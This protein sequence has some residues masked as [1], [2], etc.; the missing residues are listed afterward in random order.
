MK[1]LYMIITV[2]LFLALA[3][4]FEGMIRRI[5]ARVQSRQGPPI[6]QPYLDLLKLLG[7]ENISADGNWAFRIA[8]VMALASILSVIAFMPLGFEA[9][10]SE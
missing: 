3:P 10:C 5:T 8:P 2:I 9:N 1:V 4:L 6:I 7:K